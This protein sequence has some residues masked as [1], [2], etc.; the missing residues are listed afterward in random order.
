MEK[1]LNRNQIDYEGSAVGEKDDTQI[2]YQVDSIVKKT[3]KD[4][5]I[6]PLG[7]IKVKGGKADDNKGIN[8]LIV[9]D[10]F[11]K[12]AQAFV[13][14]KQTATMVA[15]TLWDTMVGLR[16]SSLTKVNPLRIIS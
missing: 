11:T 8:A 7:T 4:T 13:T 1:E 12:Y 3:T 2:V 14:P 10:H 16:R 15:R 5:T 6:T 9:T